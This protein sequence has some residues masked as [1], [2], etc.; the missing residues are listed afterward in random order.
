MSGTYTSP[1]EAESASLPTA[2]FLPG[3]RNLW[4]RGQDANGNWGPASRLSLVVNS[5][6]V[7]G[8]KEG[9][10]VPLQLAQNAPNP[11]V[12]TTTI[13]FGLP[14][15][16]MMRL[17]IYDVGGR[18]VRDLVNGSLPAGLHNV[19]WNRTDEKGRPVN[20]GV[21]YYRMT[22]AEKSLVRRMVVLN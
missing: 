9:L 17:T 10:P 21:F 12:A 18:R 20:S 2:N 3:A 13:V 11:V 15:P 16:T 14:A 5:D 4:V 8:V 19:T 1:K 22:T 7:V 6:G